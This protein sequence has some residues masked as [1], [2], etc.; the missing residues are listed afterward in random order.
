VRLLID[1][2]LSPLWVEALKGPGRDVR[3]WSSVGDVA[4]EDEVIV[5]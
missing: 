5:T 2:N 1:M 3:H 4:A